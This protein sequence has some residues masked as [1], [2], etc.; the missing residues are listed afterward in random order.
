M[1]VI[2]GLPGAGK[3]TILHLLKKRKNVK[4]I[5]YGDLMFE[6][7][8]KRFGV[9]GRDD[10]RK[11]PFEK[12]REVQEEVGK[13]LQKEKGTILDTHCTVSTPQGYLPALPFSILKDLPVKNFVLVTAKA[14]EI[15]ARRERDKTTRSGRDSE[16]VESIQQHDL[17]NKAM[18][19]TYAAF[20]GVPALIVD[21]EEGKIEEAVKKIET[22]V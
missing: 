12:Q 4:I 18:L 7:A 8:K 21:N 17:M 15:V 5:N 10:I 9:Q 2:F 22:L 19:A 14:D 16:S 20:K 6:I 3:S 1:I 13:A 11:L